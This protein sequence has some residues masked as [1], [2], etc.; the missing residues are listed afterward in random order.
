MAAIRLLMVSLIVLIGRVEMLRAY[1]ATLT[2]KKFD[3]LREIVP[4]ATDIGLLVNPTGALAKMEIK[5]MS[6]ATQR[7]GQHLHI[8]NVSN[9]DEINTAM[10]GDAHRRLSQCWITR[11]RG[12]PN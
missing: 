9:E 5:E 12:G 4:Q 2:A 7:L 3:L 11:R 6:E 8:A 1:A 10:A